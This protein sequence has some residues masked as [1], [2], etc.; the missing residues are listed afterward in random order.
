MSSATSRTTTSCWL[1]WSQV[2]TKLTTHRSAS[3]STSNLLPSCRRKEL[4][5]TIQPRE[6]SQKGYQNT[7]DQYP[8][9]RCQIR[10]LSA[11]SSTTGTTSTEGGTEDKPEKEVDNGLST[12]WIRPNRPLSGDQGNYGEDNATTDE[13]EDEDTILRQ[14]DE[15]LAALQ[16]REEKEAVE[17]QQDDWS[18]STTTT[19]DWLQTRRSALLQPFPLV[20]PSAVKKE[21]EKSSMSS[22]LSS[23]PTTKKDGTTKSKQVDHDKEQVILVTHQEIT[24]IL[25][26]LGATKVNV[27][28]DDP[29]RPRM[30]GLPLKGMVFCSGNHPFHIASLYRA[31]QDYMDD[32]RDEYNLPPDDDDDDN[33]DENEENAE[34]RFIFQ[35]METERSRTDRA[36]RR[37]K[38]DKAV[39]KHTTKEETWRI[40]DCIDYVV[41]IQD[42]ATRDHFR[43]EYLW[44]GEDPLWK[45]NLQDENAVDEYVANHPPGGRRGATAVDLM[46]PLD[47]HD[48]WYYYHA[49]ATAPAAHQSRRRRQQQAKEGTVS[50]DSPMDEEDEHGDDG[51]NPTSSRWDRSVSSRKNISKLEKRRWT[52][53]SQYQEEKLGRSGGRRRRGKSLSASRS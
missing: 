26:R 12:E 36:S 11:S 27:I 48:D 6:I 18:N 51:P 22:S 8:F 50:F 25:E 43:L 49:L 53:P 15:E 23:P 16:Q 35:E 21:H 44:S 52:A 47:S 45:L 42:D 5:Q 29:L 1:L 30:G 40:L 10:G 7:P 37:T 13:V 3:S 39:R 17:Q 20:V 34:Y 41:H 14:L 38:N 31:L 9:S 24:E 46:S 2:K 33:D 32:K 28:L 4:K 19:V